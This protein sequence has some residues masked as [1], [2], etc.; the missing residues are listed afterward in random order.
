MDLDA[1]AHNFVFD[2]TVVY[3]CDSCGHGD[4]RSF[5]HDC[6]QPPWEEEWDMEWSAD[7]APEDMDHLR[8][9][10]T[11]C[12]SPTRFSCVCAAHERLRETKPMLAG[13][14]IRDGARIPGPITRKTIGIR[15]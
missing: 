14:K 15:R 11:S 4:L 10:F 5:S 8:A 1:A 6:F 9:A 2:H 3:A 7:I 13:T 12:P